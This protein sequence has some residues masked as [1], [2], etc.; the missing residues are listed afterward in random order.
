MER[1]LGEREREKESLSAVH[2][3]IIIDS[4]KVDLNTF[5]DTCTFSVCTNA[6]ST[7]C[8]PVHAL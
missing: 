1:A 7:N 3:S 6:L 5:L 2:H 8:N 4:K